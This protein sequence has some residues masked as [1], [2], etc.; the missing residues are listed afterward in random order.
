MPLAAA[1]SVACARPSRAPSPA[2]AVRRAL[3]RLALPSPPHNALPSPPHSPSRAPVRCARPAC[4]RRASRP[5]LPLP[6]IVRARPSTPAVRRARP[7]SVHAE[8]CRARPPSVHAEL[9]HARP[10]S[11][12]DALVPRGEPPR[13]LSST[14]VLCS[15]FVF[16]AVRARSTL[17]A[18]VFV[19]PAYAKW[20]GEGRGCGLRLGAS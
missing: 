10:P 8:L 15:E 6:A 17:A 12:H 3:A 7:P 20:L 14:S 2:L 4:P 5:S 18:L 1:I 9:R 11:V 16:G 13:L 19:R